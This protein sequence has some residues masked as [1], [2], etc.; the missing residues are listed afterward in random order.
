MRNQG[1][2]TLIETQMILHILG[3][4]VSRFDSDSG[5]W[6]QARPTPKV[7][8]NERADD[9]PPSARRPMSAVASDIASPPTP[10]IAACIELGKEQIQTDALLHELAKC[11]RPVLSRERAGDNARAIESPPPHSPLHAD[12]L[13]RVRRQREINHRLRCLTR[14][15]VG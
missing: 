12:L 4:D 3:A 5:A 10:V 13:D 11:L 15:L 9:A 8:P 1:R 6:R 7:D 2:T 14:R